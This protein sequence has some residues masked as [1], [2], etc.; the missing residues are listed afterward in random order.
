M[1]DAQR[2]SDT[3]T[4]PAWSETERSAAL[5]SYGILDTPREADFDDLAQ[6]AAD[7]CG[8]PIALVSLVDTERQFFKAG[9]GLDD[10]RRETPIEMSFCA[11]ALAIDDVMVVEDAT[12]DPRFKDNPFVTGAPHIRFYAGAVMQTPE[13]LPIGTLC[14]IDTKPRTLDVRQLKTLRVLA[15]QAMSQIE[16]RRVVVEQHTALKK[17]EAAE[18][19]SSFLA[20]L[21]EQS[22]D[23]IGMTELD[24]RVFFLNDAARGMVGL[25]RDDVTNTRIVDCLVPEDRGAIDEI[26]LPAVAAKG[27]WEGELRLRHFTTGEAIPCLCNVFPL[28]DASGECVGYGTVNKNNSQQKQ[29]QLR[30]ADI[31]SEMAHRMKNTLAI[32]QAIVTQTLRQVSSIEEGRDAIAGRLVALSQAQDMLTT[33]GG[34]EAHIEEVVAAALAPHRVGEGRFSISGPPVTVTSAQGLGLSLAIHELATNAAKYGALS[35]ASGG[36][37]VTWSLPGPGPE[38]FRFEWTESGGPTVSK[39]TRTGFGSRL[40]ERIVAAYFDGEAKLSYESAGVRFRLD[41]EVPTG[42]A[43]PQQEPG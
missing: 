24:G 5:R 32:V 38:A 12:A 40:M 10:A 34:S 36:I 31:T 13:G 2:D 33:E 11:H 19:E 35:T 30:R 39:P 4:G 21:V 14:V 18:R 6:I 27:S 37:S 25:G 23:F 26:V 28:Q 8:T 9:I 15:R 43:G 3:E 42:A 22:S 41:G 20:R 16:L 17:A 7:I 1:P 29:E